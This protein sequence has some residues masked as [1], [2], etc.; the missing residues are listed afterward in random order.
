[1]IWE[2]VLRYW[3]RTQNARARQMAHTTLT[4]MA[5]GGM[6][7]QVGGGFHR[8]SVDSHWLVPHFEKMLYDNGQLASLYLHGWLAFGDP[9]VPA[10][11][12]RDARL[13]PARDDRSR[14]AAS[15]RR[16][17]PTP[18]ATRASSSSGRR[19]SSA[20]CWATA[21]PSTPAATGAWTAARTSRARASSTSRA[22]PTPSGS[23]RSGRSS[24][25][26]ASAGSIPAATTRCWRRGTASPAAHSPRPAARSAGPTT[27]PPP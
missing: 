4:M 16:R 25:R 12:R 14:P 22:S 1:M 19:T 7:D 10:D 15:T 5:R 8:Y 17:T 24:T 9:G 13:R 27:S 20:R 18:R 3:K 23:R 2:F 11:L 26:R 6:Y 21:T